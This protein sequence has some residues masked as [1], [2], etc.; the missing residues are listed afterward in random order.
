MDYHNP[1]D[2]A[3]VLLWVQLFGAKYMVQATDGHSWGMMPIS[4]KGR[5]IALVAGLTI[6]WVPYLAVWA[7]FGHSPLDMFAAI[8][9]WWQ[10]GH[11]V[12]Y[13]A[14]IGL[15]ACLA[16]P[17]QALVAFFLIRHARKQE[18]TELA[19]MHYWRV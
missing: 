16:S 1:M 3:F 8:P 4:A 11:I 10:A 13:A 9:T 17:V 14:A 5:M 18:L 7:T 6:I 19:Q 2:W 12:G 15:A